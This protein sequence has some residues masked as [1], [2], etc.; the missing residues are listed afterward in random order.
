VVLCF[1]DKKIHASRKK[2]FDLD[3]TKQNKKQEVSVWRQTAEKVHPDLGSQLPE[4]DWTERP[5]ERAT[6]Q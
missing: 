5:H 6:A 1:A 4:D 2:F 3:V